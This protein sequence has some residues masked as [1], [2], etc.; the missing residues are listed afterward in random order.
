MD[1][2]R[3]TLLI[4]GA[5]FI[6]L[7][8]AWERIKRRKQHDR[9]AR[10]GIADDAETHIIGKDSGDPETDSHLVST[11]YESDPYASTYHRSDDDIYID[12]ELSDEFEKQKD[13]SEL[14]SPDLDVDDEQQHWQSEVS[15]SLQENINSD[16]LEPDLDTDPELVDNSI[17]DITTELEALEEIISHEPEQ[18]EMDLGDLDVDTEPA[19]T[20]PDRIIVVHVL[21]K[22][23]E[24][25]KGADILNSLSHLGLQYGEMNVF[26]CL[27]TNNKSIFSLVNAVEP[28]IFDLS[29]MD[30]M[31]TPALLLMMSLPNPLPAL[32]AYDGMLEAARSLTSSLDG[33]LCDD[34]R[35]VLTRQAID[36]LRAELA[37]L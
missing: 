34:T 1:S 3:I 26:H 28:G 18:D 8:Y 11:A 25:F 37:S 16:E 15:T 19:S 9:Y 17:E 27:G 24:V 14:D 22:E 31:I 32:E 6:A 4:L 20:E 21:A 35:S 13:E 12:E 7:I 2:L 29:E 5:I 36:E 30:N 23:G 10:W 33:R